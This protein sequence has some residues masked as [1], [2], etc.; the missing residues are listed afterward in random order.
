MTST[1]NATGSELDAALLAERLG[2]AE[3]VT[4]L[5]VR[6]PAEFETAHIPGSINLPLDQLGGR[7]AEVAAAVTGPVVLVCQSGVRAEQARTRLAG[8][9]L[10]SVQV[11]RGGVNAYER[12]DGI[13]ERGRE[14]W[15]MERQVRLVAGSLVLT[16]TLAGLR[17]KPLLAVSGGVGLGLVISALTNTCT[18]ARVLAKLP[19]NQ[20]AS[21]PDVDGVL[22]ALRAR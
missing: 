19:Y 2:Q 14:R 9:G 11:L 7:A 13:L 5:D 18:M 4:L 17:V 3:A 20:G 16:G 15:A 6:T 1:L 12:A 22:A 10:T 21:E 8:H